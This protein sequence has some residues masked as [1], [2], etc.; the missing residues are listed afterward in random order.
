MGCAEVSSAA[1]SVPA[2]SP[3]SIVVV[4]PV[5][6]FATYG[7]PTVVAPCTRPTYDSAS[8]RVPAPWCSFTTET[9]C[10]PND[11]TTTENWEPS[12]RSASLFGTSA[13]DVPGRSPGT[14]RQLTRLPSLK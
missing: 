1:Y 14:L 8:A 6:A 3:V 4:Q 5:I 10:E 9:T 13:K 11:R 12:G 7:R 2:T